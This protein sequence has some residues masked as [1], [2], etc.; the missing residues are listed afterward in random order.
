[1]PRGDP[2]L[3]QLV[4]SYGL[5]AVFVLITLDSCGVP[6]PSEVIM[7]VAGTLAAAGHLNL[8][9]VVAVGVLASL[10]GALAA[11]GLAARFGPR[12]LLGPG[13]WVGFRRH[14]LELANRWFSR[15]GQWAVLVGRVVPVVRGYVSFP[16]GLA[17]V[18]PLRFSTLTLAGSL[19]WCAGLAAAGYVLG[20]NYRQVS[21]PIGRAAWVVGALLAV[22]VVAWFVRGRSASV[23]RG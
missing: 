20:A 5:T 16:A 14:H 19:P 21:G 4:E 7:P 6:L 2:T 13:R 15:H 9:A 23:D 8:P 10:L 11:Y 12:V 18:P 3:A 17:G 22:L 1:L